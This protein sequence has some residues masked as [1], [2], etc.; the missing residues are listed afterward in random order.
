MDIIIPLE[1]LLQSLSDNKVWLTEEKFVFF[2]NEVKYLKK[3]KCFNLGRYCK[4]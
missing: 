4:S 1:S 3:R 2:L